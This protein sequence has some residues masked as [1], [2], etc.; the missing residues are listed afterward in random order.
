MINIIYSNNK[1]RRYGRMIIKSL[2]LMLAFPFFILLAMI[3]GI[4]LLATEL[5]FWA[6]NWN[7]DT[8]E[9]YNIFYGKLFL[10]LGYLVIWLLAWLL[11]WESYGKSILR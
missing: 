6:W 3:C 2:T 7:E 1:T 9:Y 10:T 4:P 8:T 11:L 5:T